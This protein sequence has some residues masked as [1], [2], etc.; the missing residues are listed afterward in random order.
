M[1]FE[2]L[3]E[4]VMKARDT[5]ERK[6]NILNGAKI[7]EGWLLIQHK[8]TTQ[9]DTTWGG[10]SCLGLSPGWWLPDL[11]IGIMFEDCCFLPQM[12]CLECF[13]VREL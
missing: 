11:G 8:Q 10:T 7:M 2:M 13:L 4:V 3:D 6:K 9:Q 1:G 12:K 5:F